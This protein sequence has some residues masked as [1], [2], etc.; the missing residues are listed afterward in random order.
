M[1][2]FHCSENLSKGKWVE[3]PTQLLQKCIETKTCLFYSK[4][5]CLTAAAA[6][7]HLQR[8]VFLSCECVHLLLLRP[9]G[10]VWPN[11]LAR[12][13]P[14]SEQIRFLKFALRNQISNFTSHM[15]IRYWF[16]NSFMKKNILQYFTNL[17]A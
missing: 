5:T 2:I 9:K 4:S 10:A 16:V 17:Y 12:L 6:R 14:G 3:R 13:P 15:Y 1:V 8:L 7:V 11:G